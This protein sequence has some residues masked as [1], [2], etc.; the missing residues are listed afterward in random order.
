MRWQLRRQSLCGRISPPELRDS[1]KRGMYSV[2]VAEERRQTV[3]VELLNRFAESEIPCAVLKGCSLAALYRMPTLRE[4]GDVD[5][6]V[7]KE[8]EDKAISL[9]KHEG[10][11]IRKRNP[12]QHESA[13]EHPEIGPIEVHAYLFREEDRKLWFGRPEW[14]ETLLPFQMQNIGNDESISVLAVQ[15]N[16]EFLC[17]HFV[18][19]FIRERCCIRNILDVGL[20]LHAHSEIVDFERL[21]QRMKK[22]QYDGILQAVLTICVRYMGMSAARFPGY[23][24]V[25]EET[26]GAFL[27]D[28]EKRCADDD[29]CRESLHMYEAYL[30]SKR[31]KHAGYW[32]IKRAFWERLYALVPSKKTLQSRFFYAE[33]HAWLLPAAWLLYLISGVSKTVVRL[34]RNSSPNAAQIPS[35]VT[36]R[37]DLFKKLRIMK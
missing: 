32:R 21:W 33:R 1:V 35:D 14:E 30:F 9:L 19:H 4:S 29:D 17:L 36:T 7:G 20:F 28:V 22:C 24:P 26:L 25:D 16:A 13:G 18:K 34:L 23:V 2:I 11:V 5:L 31:R 12:M 10:V 27:D 8:Y 37:I 15:D 3:I 6:Y